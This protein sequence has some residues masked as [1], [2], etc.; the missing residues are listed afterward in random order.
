MSGRNDVSTLITNP[1]DV[2]EDWMDYA[3][4]TLGVATWQKDETTFAK[5]KA[6]ATAYGYTCAGVIQS[7]QSL[8]F[9]LQ[10][11]L[12]S[13]LGYFRFDNEGKLQVFLEP[14]TAETSIFEWFDEW[15]QMNLEV[16]GNIE[17]IINRVIINYAI[18]YTQIDRRFKGG[19]E[20]SYFR[21]LDDTNSASRDRNGERSKPFDFD[22]TRNTATVEAVR[23]ILFD[24]YADGEILVD[25]QGQDFKYMPLELGDDIEAQIS[26]VLHEDGSVLDALPYRIREKTQ[27]LDDFT[28]TQVLQSIGYYRNLNSQ[29]VY[30][31]TNAVYIGTQPI[32][33]G[34]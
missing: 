8:G 27:N 15:E 4:E 25:Y 11:I 1:I 14:P 19:G 5:A 33:I 17:N 18:S 32:N 10:T 24:R 21:T 23:D 9:W 16:S 13:F 7:N 3:T 12:N 26:L 28:T 29:P 2:I 31:G 22:W 34:G 30:I 6:D 20:S